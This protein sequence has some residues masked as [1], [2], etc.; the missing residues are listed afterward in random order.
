MTLERIIRQLRRGVL[1]HV[2]IVRGPETNH[3]WRFAVETPGLCRYFGRCWNCHEEVKLADTHCPTCKCD[4]RFKHMR[5]L[6]AAAARRANSLEDTGELTALSPD[7]APAPR[8]SKPREGS[9]ASSTAKLEGSSPSDVAA[10]ADA[11]AAVH[12]VAGDLD[13]LT[14]ALKQVGTQPGDAVVD[15]PPRVAG[16][17]VIWFAAGL[18][19]IALVV[20]MLV[21]RWRDRTIQD[22]ESPTA[23]LVVPSD[24]LTQRP[25]DLPFCRPL[26]DHPPRG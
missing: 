14:D 17:S 9:P 4:L 22:S 8:P 10:R 20:L 25:E 13:E 6:A 5:A 1:T 24:A 7:N 21:S 11:L 12:V 23:S 16:L 19:I 18:V 3:Q 2:S 26:T 15:Q